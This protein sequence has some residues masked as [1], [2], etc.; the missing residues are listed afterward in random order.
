MYINLHQYLGITAILPP[1]LL[2]LYFHKRDVYPEPPKILWTSFFYGMGAAILIF[3]VND[4]T[5]IFIPDVNSFVA[6]GAYEAFFSAA[7]PEEFCKLLI[8][9]GYCYQRPEFDEPMDGIVYGAVVSLG[10]ACL[11][12]ITYVSFGGL[13]VAFARAWT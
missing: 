1:I 3:V 10:F 2:V 7:I 12:N 8:F 13:D 6:R 5:K 9:L 4:F 11:E